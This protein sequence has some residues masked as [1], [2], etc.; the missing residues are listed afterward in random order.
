MGTTSPD[1]NGAVRRLLLVVAT[2]CGE[3]ERNILRA[4][5]ECGEFALS[6]ARIKVPVEQTPQ[7][8]VERA[9]RALDSRVFG[10]RRDD[11]S[12]VVSEVDASE[13]P[14]LA[15]GLGVFAVVD[16]TGTL[17]SDPGYRSIPLLALW[18]EGGAASQLAEAV[19][20]RLGTHHGTVQVSVTAQS[21][22]P[23]HTLFSGTCFIDHRSLAR[24]VGLVAR[25]VPMV[26]QAALARHGRPD[27]LSTAPREPPPPM[28]SPLVLIRRL[29]ASILHRLLR[30]DQ[31]GMLVYRDQP[32]ARLHQPWATV[33][34]DASA[35]WADPFL[36]PHAGGVGLFFEEL[37]FVSGK[38]RISFVAIDGDGRPGQPVVVLDKPW[39][40]SYPFQFEW[41]GRRYMIPESSANETVDLY[42]CTEFPQHWRFVRTLI[43]GRRLADATIVNWQGRLW[44]FS[45]HGHPG[46]SN[47]DELHIYSADDLQGPWQ[48]HALN[49]VK[50]DAGSARPAGAMWV[51]NGRIVRPTQD[52][53]NRY[54]D[55]V[56]FQEVL[57]LD[58]GRFEERPLDRLAPRGTSAGAAVH[59]FN[60]MT[61][62]TV[63]DAAGSVWRRW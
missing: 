62:F 13:L 43:E 51:E 40:L 20:H 5:D 8:L 61:E 45:A 30:R 38:G 36:V 29:A 60:E 63:I 4:I 49:P 28:L 32:R 21:S 47:Y 19:R 59:T 41:H 27:E 54:G 55:G 25:K 10:G 48:P 22:G 3:S 31:W 50:I 7:S 35:F 57:V 12:A 18:F 2:N 1:S 46:A 58:D 17:R 23:A 11:S 16:L 24:S 53:R 44:M 14:A 39:H 6:V 34:P 26:L 15:T 33:M 52:C 37:P 9:Y 42:E 56:A